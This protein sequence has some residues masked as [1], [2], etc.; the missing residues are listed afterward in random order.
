[1]TFLDILT[2]LKSSRSSNFNFTA[3]LEFHAPWPHAMRGGVKEGKNNI[4]HSIDKK[5][6]S[7]NWPPLVGSK[8]GARYRKKV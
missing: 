5:G 7:P 8:M 4:L 3:V 6:G 2:D 1:M